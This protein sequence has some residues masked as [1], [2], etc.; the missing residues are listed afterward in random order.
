MPPS[1]AQGIA[2]VR[3]L[4]QLEARSGRRI[5]D[6][7]DLICGTSTGGILAVALGLRDM[8]LEDCEQIYRRASA[9]CQL[10]VAA[11]ALNCHA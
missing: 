1:H 9:T 2:I 3:L 4:R 11:A 5:R 6:L 7:F 8:S 10:S